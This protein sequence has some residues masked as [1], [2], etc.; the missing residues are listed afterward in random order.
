M[1]HREYSVVLYP[2]LYKMDLVKNGR[3]RIVYVPP[4]VSLAAKE[5]AI[6][7]ELE[8]HLK[9]KSLSESLTGIEL[10]IANVEVSVE[11]NREKL[12]EIEIDDPIIFIC[13]TLMI[14]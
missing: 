5:V 12:I 7:H 1:P 14:L 2:N 11:E 13:K 10:A 8:C 9:P 3:T 4:R 6:K